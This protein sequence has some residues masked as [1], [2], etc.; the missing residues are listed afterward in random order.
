MGTGSIIAISIV[1]V[2]IL[3]IVIVGIITYKEI[4]PTIENINDLNETVTQQTNYYT[5][6]GEH[7][8]SRVNDL[9]ERVE[10][11]QEELDEKNVYF[12]DFLDEKGQFQTSLNYLEA[13]AGEYTKGIATNVKD[14]L[15]ED[16]P[17]IMETFKRTFK[18]TVQ[19]QKLRYQK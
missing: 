14:E 3:A 11:L 13:H 16:G 10:F 7:L 5:R 2:S 1:V 12:Q 19:K 4:K 8:T 15:K 17:K 9:K 6:E 18:K